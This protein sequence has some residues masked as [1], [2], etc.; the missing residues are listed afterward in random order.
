MTD[1]YGTDLSRIIQDLLKRIERLEAAQRSGPG[2]TV[3]KAS[4][5]FNLPSGSAATPPSGANLIYD[6]SMVRYVDSSGTNRPL[7][8]V[9]TTTPQ[10][11]TSFTSPASIVSAPTASNYN[12]LRA[13][14]AMLQ[15]CLRDVINRGAAI[16]LWPSP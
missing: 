16:P 3:G 4:G 13:D 9:Q 12:A 11:P 14:A 2:L 15:V 6:G 8:I 1:L 5:P 7:G 10:Y